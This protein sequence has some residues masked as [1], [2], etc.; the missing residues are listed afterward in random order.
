MTLLGKY[1]RILH[2]GPTG[3]WLVTIIW[4]EKSA[5][6]QR[7]RCGNRQSSKFRNIF[8]DCIWNPNLCWVL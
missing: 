6:S 3:A 5:L 1:W 7:N 4:Q 2:A 8:W